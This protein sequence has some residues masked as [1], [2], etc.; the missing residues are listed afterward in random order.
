MP[1]A[2]PTIRRVR[3]ASALRTMAADWLG[4]T[5]VTAVDNRTWDHP[6]TGLRIRVLSAGAVAG[7]VT[8]TTALLGVLGHDIAQRDVATIYLIGGWNTSTEEI[9]IIGWMTLG[10][11][12]RSVNGAVAKRAP[13]AAGA[14]AAVDWPVA[15]HVRTGDMRR[16]EH[17]SALLSSLEAAE[18][19]WRGDAGAARQRY[20]GVAL[21]SVHMRRFSDVEL[22]TA[23]QM[24]EDREAGKCHSPETLHATRKTDYGSHM[25]GALS[26]LVLT[27]WRLALDTAVHARGDGGIDSM[28]PGLT[29]SIDAKANAQRW[30]QG[31]PA[32]LRI[33]QEH[34]QWGVA[35]DVY[36]YVALDS[37][38]NVAEVLGW[39]FLDEVIRAGAARRLAN[40]PKYPINYLAPIHVLRPT[41]SLL[42]LIERGHELAGTPSA[43]QG[44][45]RSDPSN[46]RRNEHSAR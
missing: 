30:R 16:L 35:A 29:L 43:T 26:E 19:P 34:V 40:D 24:A 14:R 20:K 23:R 3:I 13:T 1:F 28:I 46:E 33:K 41:P 27:D 8:P 11:I 12:I 4:L 42:A 25:Q 17:L 18:S 36:C 5:D 37:H 9:A 21:E 39:I 6:T 15:Y 7:P 10:D 38:A 22:S 32:D 45:G 31:D 44:E 2:D